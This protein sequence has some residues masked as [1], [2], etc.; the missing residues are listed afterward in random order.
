[1]D[2]FWVEGRVPQPAI[3]DV[4]KAAMGLESE[5]YTHQLHFYYPSQGGIQAVTDAI[6]KRINKEG[7]SKI[8]TKFQ[9]KKVK[10]EGNGWVVKG[11]GGGE[12]V[13][14]RLVTTIHIQDFINSYEGASSEVKDAVQKLKW[15]SIHL[16]MIG[17]DNPKLNDIHWA[18]IPDSHIF[19][20]RISFP[21]NMS[22]N[23]VPKGH[24]AVLAET[25]FAPDGEKSKLTEKEI[26]ERTIEDLHSIRVIDK[27]QVGFSKLV[28]YKYAYVVYDL[29]YQQNIKIVEDFAKSEGITLLGRFSEF[30]YYNSDKCVESALEK[31]G[32]F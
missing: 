25:T 18:Y 13:Y 28:S 3:D 10:K 1:M 26:I 27:K 5:G 14:D 8:T 20:N 15:N 24:S 21:A 4:K 12:R 23:T 2:L 19:P 6:A 22:P 17:L 32:L 9:V 11:R 7:K 30:R 16:V 29:D 31:A